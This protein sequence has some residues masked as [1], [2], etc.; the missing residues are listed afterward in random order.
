V[1]SGWPA[2]KLH[3]P[4]QQSA[5]DAHESPGCVQNDAG[6]QTLPAHSPEQHSVLW[7]HE[8]P[9]VL[10]VLLSGVHVPLQTPLQHCD[11]E[12]QASPSDV[13]AGMVQTPLAQLPLQHWPGVHA[14]PVFRQDVPLSLPD[15]LS[16]PLSV[17]PSV[18]EPESVVPP[19]VP[20]PPSPPAS[21][22]LPSPLPSAA[23]ASPLASLT[24]PSL[25]VVPSLAGEESL[26]PAPSPPASTVAS[27]GASSVASPPVPSPPALPSAGRVPS[28]PVVPSLEPESPGVVPSP[29]PLPSR[30]WEPL[31]R[32]DPSSPPASPNTFVA[33]V[34]PHPIASEQP[35]MTSAHATK[36]DLEPTI[37]VSHPSRSPFQ[38]AATDVRITESPPSMWNAMAMKPR[39]SLTLARITGP[40]RSGRRGYHANVL[41]FSFCRAS[42]LLAL[43]LLSAGACHRDASPPDPGAGGTAAHSAAPDVPEAAAVRA[44]PPN[45][46]GAT[47]AAIAANEGAV[48]RY[49]D[50]TRIAPPRLQA[51]RSAGDVRTQ[52]SDT[53]GDV[54]LAMTS[55]KGVLKIA[56]RGP[57]FLIVFDDPNDLSRQL[58]GWVPE[59]VFSSDSPPKH[60]RLQC[61][62]GQVP[63]FVRAKT[64][65]ERCELSCRQDSTCPKGTACIGAGVLSNDGVPGEPTKYCEPRA[66]PLYTPPRPPG[67]G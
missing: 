17:P 65:D 2:V 25:P 47:I 59:R 26:P 5:A 4:L 20:L 51:T 67:S 60:V 15:P 61:A 54:I 3:A 6:A 56:S 16:V 32:V 8:L 62:G 55:N 7:L 22:L 21:A 44:P 48:T 18:P 63:V 41:A 28:L 35:A 45:E 53:G 39:D 64:D 11:G 40:H 66:V 13:Q 10:H 38:V 52:A 33:S 50:E 12:E 49:P 23:P 34:P 14:L 29:P 1:P 9:S 57:F 24:V 43:T 31:S 36:H 27:A 42:A 46:A 30:P 58:M 19:S 37:I